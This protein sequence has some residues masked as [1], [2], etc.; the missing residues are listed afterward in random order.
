MIKTSQTE[1][2]TESMTMKLVCAS[3]VFLLSTFYFLSY[4]LYDMNIW[5]EGVPLNGA[6]RMFDGE[7]P[8]RDFFSYPPGR[9]LI[10]YTAMSIGGRNV[11]SPRVGMALLSGLFCVLIWTIARRTGLKKAAYVPVLLYLIMPMYY[12]YRFFTFCLLLNTWILDMQSNLRSWSRSLLT[13]VLAVIVIWTRFELGLM[14]LVIL[15]LMAIYQSIRRKEGS[16]IR[17]CLP[18]LI[19]ITGFIL[20]IWYI[21]GWESGYDYWKLYWSTAIGGIGEMSLPWPPLWSIDYLKSVSVLFLIQDSMFYFSAIILTVTFFFAFFS[22]PNPG[23][24]IKIQTI[25]GLFGFALVIWR[26]GYGNLIRCSPP[27]TIAASWLF[28]RNSRF[29]QTLTFIGV[30]IVSMLIFDSLW[31]NPSTYQSIGV[32]RN[33]S[34]KLE[35]PNFSVKLDPR[36]CSSF[37]EL[38][39]TLETMRGHGD[40]TMLSLPFHPLLNF[41]TGFKNKNYYEWLLPGMFSSTEQYHSAML[42]MIQGKPYIVALNDEPI[43]NLEDRRFSN[44]Y[45]D[46]MIWLARDY[47]L[48]Q[49]L[50]GFD[51][52]V[53]REGD[54]VDLLDQSKSSVV[55]TTGTF[56]LKRMTILDQELPIISQTDNGRISFLCRECDESLFHSMIV[57][58]PPSLSEENSC[59]IRIFFNAELVREMTVDDDSRYLNIVANLPETTGE[60]AIIELDCSWREYSENQSVEW[61]NPVCIK[62]ASAGIVLDK[63]CSHL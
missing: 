23:I 32:M 41:V 28:C 59:L 24:S 50:S 56:E 35:H 20:E 55:M 38:I 21:G 2:E 13:G 1:K 52:Y 22:K 14:L 5:D 54:I 18:S 62:S 37:S 29:K 39:S 26:T 43:D 16:L 48:W 25:M 4:C 40:G 3:V 17:Q 10:Y 15:P 7:R 45:P 60:T 57:P 9:Y 49:K 46:A 31:F 51:L 19:M 63:Y 6:I 27:I 44:Q 11:E 8:I 58:H 30:V 47:Y 42:E 61:L 34:A 33:K 36:D 53:R 12:Y